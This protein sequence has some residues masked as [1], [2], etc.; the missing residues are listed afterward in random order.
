[1]GEAFLCVYAIN[2]R[3]SFEALCQLREYI[4][5]VQGRDDVLMVLVGNKSDL[6][7]S[8]RQVSQQEAAELAAKCGIPFFETSAKLRSKVDDAFFEL[9]R[10]IWKDQERH[11][12]TASRQECRPKPTCLFM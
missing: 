7:D 6:D 12:R 11:P 2:S 3:S 4:L 8:E 10:E 5:R 1:M 9:V